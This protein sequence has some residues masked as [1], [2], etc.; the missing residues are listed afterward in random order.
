MYTCISYVYNKYG[1]LK[2]CRLRE[3]SK[4]VKIKLV[5]ISDGDKNK[6]IFD[7]LSGVAWTILT[8]LGYYMYTCIVYV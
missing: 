2:C 4:N 3:I 6:I 8:K 1:Y 5:G 7:Y